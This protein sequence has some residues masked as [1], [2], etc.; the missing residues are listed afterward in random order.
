M[1]SIHILH[2]VRPAEGGML[3]HVQHLLRGSSAS[4]QVSVACPPDS[5]LFREAPEG[6]R[7]VGIP[8][9]DGWAPYHDL[10]ASFRL[11]EWM[12]N[13]PVDI[14]HMH[15]AKAG[16]V[17]RLAARMMKKTPRLV[18]TI[19]NFIEPK[20]R[21]RKRVYQGL[22]QWLLRDTDCLITVSHALAKHCGSR[23]DVS[24][25]KIRII[26]NGVALPREPFTVT[27]AR[28]FLG[29]ASD[30]FVIGTISRLIYEKGVS[31]L[32][33]A[34][35]TL[36]RCGYDMDLV[37]IGDGPERDKLERMAARIDTKGRIRFLGHVPD[38]VRF[39]RGFDL[40]VIPSLQEGFGLVAAESML[41]GVPL[42]ATFVGGL[43]EVVQD[44]ETG[45][46]VQP[47]DACALAK[48]VE[49]MYM[50]PPLKRQLAMKGKE[51]A[52]AYFTVS[53]ML[54]ETLEVYRACM[55][56]RGAFDEEKVSL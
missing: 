1:H 52:T 7:R 41:A 30:R 22:E 9:Y 47:G 34:F 54:Q 13:N 14:L 46:L 12:E 51:Y 23:L 43:E 16:L 36:L 29:V 8:I 35:H 4:F 27:D 2:L 42:I 18:Y 38:A 10:L 15:G 50:D 19:H 49:R 20:N 28:K 56:E 17:G 53:K 37:I 45:L 32:L 44:G 40:C 25:E 55:K 31:F 48:A 6:V 33:D 26:H 11:K 3:Q 21:W 5:R 24:E 39:L